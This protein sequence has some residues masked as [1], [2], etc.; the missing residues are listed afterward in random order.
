MD[1]LRPHLDPLSVAFADLI[2][3]LAG[4]ADA[5]LWLGAVAAC[6]A[7]QRQNACVDLQQLAGQPVLTDSETEG[8]EI[9]YPALEP[10]LTTLAGVPTVVGTPGAYTPLVLQGHRLYLYRYWDYEQHLARLLQTRAAHSEAIDPSLAQPL[11]ALYPPGARLDWQAIAL[12]SALGNRLSIITGGPGTGK[13]TTVSRMLALLLSQTPSLRVV[14]AAPTGK[15]AARMKQSLDNSRAQ[16]N[17]APELQARFPQDALTLHRLLGYIPGQI[18]FRHGPEHPLPW[19]VVIV[20]EA[21]MIDLPM[22]T[23]LVQALRPDTRL[24][25]L[26]D[27]HQLAS[28]ETGCVLGDICAAANPESFSPERIAALS[29]LTGQPTSAF[30]AASGPLDDRV[31]ALQISRRFHAQSGIG[32]LARAVNAGESSQALA[33]LEHFDDLQLQPEWRPSLLSDAIQS[34]FLPYLQTDSHEQALQAL[35]RFIFLTVLR[36]GPRSVAELNQTVEQTLRRQGLIGPQPWYHRR[37]V[38]I[39]ENDYVHQLYNGDIGVVWAPAGSPPRVWFRRADGSLRDYAPAQLGAYQTAWALTVHK[40]QGSEFDHVHLVL[41]AT[42][43]PLV[44]RELIYTG[45]T[46][47]RQR[48]TLWS[49]PEV[50]FQGI[51]QRMMR[52]SGLKELLHNG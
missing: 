44:T 31:I 29:Q 2:Q 36:R 18:E 15:A 13:T 3:E 4:S 47:G 42:P 34:G 20:D 23:R 26:G 11:Q 43:H 22:M 46:R 27:E 14:L 37:P 30:N 32:Q 45:I 19:D 6:Q 5:G 12:A 40:S 25:L 24:I 51:S 35:E 16:L 41:P 21:S 38:L 48:V 10:W 8:I 39:T 50:L 33:H 49:S 7:V 52:T 1:E 28:V 17:L 9:C